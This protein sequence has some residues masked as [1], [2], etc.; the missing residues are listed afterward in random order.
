[1]FE[2]EANHHFS[3]D[4][5]VE[6]YSSIMKNDVW[7]VGGIVKFNVRSVVLGFSQ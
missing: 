3:M 1:M 7:D 6:V 4:A 5:M 2:E